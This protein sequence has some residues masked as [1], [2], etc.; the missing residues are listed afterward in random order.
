MKDTEVQ[1]ADCTTKA[2]ENQDSEKSDATQRKRIV[3]TMVQAYNTLTEAH[4]H[5]CDEGFKK[6]ESKQTNAGKKTFH[7]CGRVKQ[8]SKKQCDAR[9][10]IFEDKSK[11]NFEIH[12]SNTGDKF[13]E[14]QLANK[15]SDK[16]KSV[17]ISCS[18]NRMTPKYIAQHINKMR[19][20]MGFFADEKTPAMRQIYY[21]CHTH[22][23]MKTPKIVELGQ[24]IEWVEANMNIPDEVD[25]PFVI[26]F[27]HSDEAEEVKFDIVISTRRMMQHCATQKVICVDATYK[28][29][30][31]GYPFIVIGAIDRTKKFHPLCFALCTHETTYDYTFVFDSLVQSVKRLTDS[32]FEPNIIISD[33]AEA[34]RNAVDAIFPNAE[35]VMCYVHVLRNVEKQKFQKK[36]NK[37]RISKDIG[38]L[39]L[40]PSRS[41]FKRNVKLFLKKWSKAEKEFT[42]YFAANWINKHS[43]WYESF[44][45]YT[46]STNNNVEG[47]YLFFLLLP[48]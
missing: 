10:M 31:L 34:I 20:E 39:H 13:D 42:E 2:N 1:A 43:N 6:H 44:A 27:D 35:Q 15:I 17:I 4:K 28:L 14:E 11:T 36:E 16:M 32:N 3:Y 12:V 25:T 48:H 24:L 9:R 30:W 23:A 8:R 38:I 41:T 22:K 47:K 19:E 5:I 40:S 46:P 29:N 7:R 26:N 33:A 45:D 18:E 37:K 21:I